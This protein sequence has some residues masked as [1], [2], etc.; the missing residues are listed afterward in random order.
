MPSEQPPAGGE[1]PPEGRL[2]ISE[3]LAAAARNAADPQRIPDALCTACVRLLP[4]SGASVAISGGWGVSVTWCAS[5]DVAARLAELQYTVGDGPCQ[6]TLE[7]GAPVLAAD[8]TDGWPPDG[9][10]NRPGGRRGDQ[11]HE[12]PRDRPGARPGD[13]PQ[14]PRPPPPPPHRPRSSQR[15][16]SVLLDALRDEACAITGTHM[17]SVQLVDSSDDTLWLESHCGFPAEFVH[18]FAVVDGTTSPRGH[19]ARRRQRIVVDDVATAP[20]FDEPSRAVVLSADCRSCQCT[21]IPGP[22]GGPQGMVSTHHAQPFHVYTLDEL[23]ALDTAVREAGAWLDRHRTAT[24]R[25]ALEDLHA[26]VLR[27]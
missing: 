25:D 21:P 2:R 4:V 18:H 16:R 24:D 6:T 9:P 11:P 10:G 27:P 5:D 19:A 13:R 12:E 8:L 7:Q 3:A 26:S 1:P 23:V 22:T 17:A 14:P 15:A 20:L